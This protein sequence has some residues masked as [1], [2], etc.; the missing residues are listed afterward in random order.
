MGVCSGNIL[1]LPT[2]AD[3]ETCNW[4]ITSIIHE[5]R[6]CPNGG[7]KEWRNLAAITKGAADYEEVFLHERCRV[8]DRNKYL[9]RLDQFGNFLLGFRTVRNPQNTCRAVHHNGSSSTAPVGKFSKDSGL[10]S[11]KSKHHID[12]HCS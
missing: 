5:F 10:C 9:L 2:N 7:L 3:S 8:Q 6:H 11:A 4:E 1:Q 12:S